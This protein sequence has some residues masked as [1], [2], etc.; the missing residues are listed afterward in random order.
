MVDALERTTNLL[1]LLLEARQP[2]TMDQIVTALEGQ[3][4]SNPASRR[5]AFERDKQLL[6]ELGVP[7]DTEVLVAHQAGQTGYRIDRARYELADLS[8]EPD[9]R[10]A[11][12]LAVAAVRSTNATFGLLKLGAEASGTT[13]V[14]APLPELDVLPALRQ[15]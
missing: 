11:L 5:G 9:E 6:R 15:A 8:L 12:Q 7:I 14:H 4:P 1:A 10:R 3:Y 13:A 2:L